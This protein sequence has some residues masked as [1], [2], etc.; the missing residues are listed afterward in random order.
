MSLYLFI[1][2]AM[3]LIITPGP[4]LIFVLTRGISSGRSAGAMS[5]VGVTSGILVHTVTTSFG[6]AVL[7][8]T[9]TLVF[10]GMKIIGGCYLIY[11]GIQMF[12]N[13]PNLISQDRELSIKKRSCFLQGFF[14]NV[15][16]PKVALFFV[17]FLPQFV[18]PN[19]EQFISSMVM[20]GL[21]YA[22]MTLP[23]LLT[24]AIFA[25]SISN[26]LHMRKKISEKI[27]YFSGSIMVLLGVSLLSPQSKL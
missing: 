23:F 16:N 13:S 7:L 15:F 4:D 17:A 6:L 10:W 27:G 26:W 24:L 22:A 20:L 8:Q 21:L 2:A 12:K 14:S 25:G 3:A 9:S 18:D 5:A 11:L 19:S 1:I